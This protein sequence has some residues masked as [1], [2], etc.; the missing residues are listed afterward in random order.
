MKKPNA[1]IIL[2]PR[3]TEK[4]AYLSGVNAYAFNVAKDANKKEVAAAI[5]EI[6]KVTPRKVT[7]VAIPRKQVS[8]RGVNRT[9]M[10][11]GGKKAYVYLKKGDS[12]EI[13]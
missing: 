10:T 8:T 7:F 6:F 9:G 12:I 4:A 11:A 3:I 1:H 5:T 2:S 13:A